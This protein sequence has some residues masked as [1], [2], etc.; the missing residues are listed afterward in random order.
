M[1]PSVGKRTNGKAKRVVKEFNIDEPEEMSE[2]SDSDQDVDV[3][4]DEQQMDMS[5]SD[6]D[7]SESE[8]SANDDSSSSGTDDEIKKILSKPKFV[9]PHKEQRK[10]K[11]NKNRKLSEDLE[12]SIL[13]NIKKGDFFGLGGRKFKIILADP[14]WDYGAFYTGGSAAEHYPPIRTEIL[15]K[16]PVDEIADDDSFLF[17][18][19]T[20]P[21]LGDALEVIKAWG[22]TYKTVHNDI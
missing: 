16:L 17:M 21:K 9:D 2:L 19:A 1:E 11:M 6:S 14:P 4:K 5:S 18:W 12:K 15:K 3:E 10:A 13:K 8:N 20:G 22:F 7:S